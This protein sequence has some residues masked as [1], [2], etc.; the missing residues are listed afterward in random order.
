MKIKMM[1]LGNLIVSVV[2]LAILIYLI[3]VSLHPILWLQITNIILVL[4]IYLPIV[5]VECLEVGNDKKKET[6]EI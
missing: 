4:T 2:L 5:I 6:K 1:K 3:I